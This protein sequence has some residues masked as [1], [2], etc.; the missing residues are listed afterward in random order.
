MNVREHYFATFIIK[1]NMRF[2]KFAACSLSYSLD[3]DPSG[4]Q[5]PFWIHVNFTSFKSSKCFKLF[6][7]AVHAMDAYRPLS[8]TMNIHRTFCFT[9]FT[10]NTIFSILF[11]L[12]NKFPLIIW[13]TLPTSMQW[14][15]TNNRK[16]NH[17][18]H[19]YS[20]QNSF[21]GVWHKIDT[22][23]LHTTLNETHYLFYAIDKEPSF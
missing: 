9:H 8:L 7:P 2:Q 4:I 16:P 14:N 3:G 10:H 18:V 22:Q 13:M 23:S 21:N 1:L 15:R 11:S 12:K 20:I 17:K 6:L 19:T 5:F